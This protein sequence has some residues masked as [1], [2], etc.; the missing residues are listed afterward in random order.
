MDKDVLFLVVAATVAYLALRANQGVAQP[1][2]QSSI[3]AQNAYGFAPAA[4][5]AHR[6]ANR[7]WDDE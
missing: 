4:M 1:W 2:R 7:L 6:T 5:G 3:Y